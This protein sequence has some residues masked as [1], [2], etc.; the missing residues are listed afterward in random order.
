M[1]NLT[2]RNFVAASTTGILGATLHLPLGMLLSSRSYAQERT[3]KAV[4]E[5]MDRWMFESKAPVGTLHVSRFKDPIYFLT[6]PISWVPNPDQQQHQRVTVPIGFVTDFAS[7]PR[8][9][10]SLLRPD[11]EYTYPAIV[12]DF[13]YWT[14]DRPR[15]EADEIL[16][17]GM[18][19]FK[20]DQVTITAI[21]HAVRIGGGAAWNANTALKGRGEKRVLKEFP[22]DPTITWETWKSRPDV[23]AP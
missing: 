19:D 1:S 17:L 20:I 11:G 8:V 15:E 9:F 10:W 12:H 13:M 2:R 5:W 16:R 22:Q 14:Q 7:V 3:D 4:E 21:F 18:Q 6:K 23:F